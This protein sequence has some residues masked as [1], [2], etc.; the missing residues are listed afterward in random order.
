MIKNQTEILASMRMNRKL[1]LLMISAVLLMGTLGIVLSVHRVE[2]SETIYIR[3]D[4]SI[5]PITA[6]ITSADNVTYYFTDNNY[7]SIIVQRNNVTI[8]GD[9]YTLQGIGSGTGISCR[10][11]V[12]IRNIEIHSFYYGVRIENAENNTITE[13]EIWN[14]TEGISFGE[15]WN[16]TVSWNLIRN[17]TNGISGTSWRNIIMS[18]TIANN[19]NGIRYNYAQYDIVFENNIKDNDV[20][21]YIDFSCYNN[22]FYHNNFINNT[23]QVHAEQGQFNFWDDGYPSGGNYWN[24][25]VDLNDYQGPHQNETGPDHVWDNPYEIDADNIDHYPLIPEFPTL[26]IVPL[27]MVATLLSALTYKKKRLA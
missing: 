23:V 9:G 2:A 10:R 1:G 17:N 3:A 19:T 16:N 24:E 20:G 6:N 4:G 11:N 25:Y 5:D 15:A 13:N 12:T 22:T 8:D 27:F 18:N 14:C 7:D 26:L 21:V